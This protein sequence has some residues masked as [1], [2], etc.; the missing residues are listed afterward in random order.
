MMTGRG[1]ADD[2]GVG[3]ALRD[4]RRGVRIRVVYMIMGEKEVV[5]PNIFGPDRNIHQPCRSAVGIGTV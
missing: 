2:R 5:E 3:I 1:W 4:R